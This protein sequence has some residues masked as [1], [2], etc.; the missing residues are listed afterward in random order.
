MLLLFFL[1]VLLGF[2]VFAISFP[3]FQRSINVSSTHQLLVACSW[4]NHKYSQFLPLQSQILILSVTRVR[5]SRSDLLTGSYQCRYDDISLNLKVLR[6]VQSRV[7]VNYDI[8]TQNITFRDTRWHLTDLVFVLRVRWE[9]SFRS[10]I[11]ID[12]RNTLDSLCA[13]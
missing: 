5:L 8:S 7:D 13:K 9:C 2:L 12:L 4:N 1:K 3:Y 6:T 11:W 10:T